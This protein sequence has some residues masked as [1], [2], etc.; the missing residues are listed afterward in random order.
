VATDADD[1]ASNE[2]ER[3]DDDEDN[4]SIEEINSFVVDV[5][6]LDS[7]DSPAANNAN[8]LDSDASEEKSREPNEAVAE[9]VASSVAAT[10]VEVGDGDSDFGIMSGDHSKR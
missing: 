5:G 3:N 10:E 2:V 7:S 6:E 9:A 8:C 1:E 4:A